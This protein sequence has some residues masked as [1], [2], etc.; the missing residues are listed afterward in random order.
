MSDFYPTKFSD[1]LQT[2]H[3]HMHAFLHFNKH[4]VINMDIWYINDRELDVCEACLAGTF[5]VME[6]HQTEYLDVTASTRQFMRALDSVRMGQWA[7]AYPSFYWGKV[8]HKNFQGH[9]DH[10]RRHQQLPHCVLDELPNGWFL[11]IL[12]K[13]R[14]D[15]LSKYLTDSIAILRKYN[16]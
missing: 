4:A 9:V 13:D 6:E 12:T 11:G 5:M 3:D 8:W 10:A 7:N 14:V 16:F 15:E 2:A 1:L